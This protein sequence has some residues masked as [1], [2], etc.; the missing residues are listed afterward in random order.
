M[1]RMDD[2]LAHMV[3]VV[4]R[5]E[6]QVIAIRRDLDRHFTTEHQEI[7]ESLVEV[8]ALRADVAEIHVAA[9][10]SRWIATEV[11]GLAG[12]AIRRGNRAP[13]R[14]GRS[15]LCRQRSGSPIC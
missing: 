7:D 9:K 3:S 6:E 2:V 10:V 12:A 5:I 1:E 15:A 14:P 4:A 11:A 8:Q 13:I